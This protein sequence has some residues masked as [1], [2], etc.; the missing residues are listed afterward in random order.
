MVAAKKRAGPGGV[1]ST[2][3]TIVITGGAGFIGSALTRHLLDRGCRVHNLDYLPN[4]FA[5]PALT[6]FQGSFMDHGIVREAMAGADCLV[7]LAATGFAREANADPARDAEENILGT[8]RLLGNAVEMGVGRVVFCSSGGTVYGT[9]R[10]VPI[11]EDAP[12]HPISAYGVSKLACEKYLRLF[13]GAAL[14]GQG[15]MSTLTLRVANPYGAGQNIAKAQGALATFCHNAVAGRP[16]QIW[17][18][19]LVERDYIDVRDVARAL[20]LAIRQTDV[21]GCEI[22]IGSGQGTSLNRL[23]EMI[24]EAMGARPQVIHQPGRSFDVARNHLDIGLARERLGWQP[25]IA[26]RDGIA[27]LLGQLQTGASR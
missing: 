6:H 10:D 15:R 22:N 24:A 18:D 4:R 3:S 23:V 25:E 19:G 20:D 12:T 9:A 14:P 2:T 11:A 21:A 16:I 27:D 17:G 26:L 7:H 5:D 8:I 13:D 1:S